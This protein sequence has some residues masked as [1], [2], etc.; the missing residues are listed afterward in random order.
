MFISLMI[1]MLKWMIEEIDNIEY[2]EN[3]HTQETRLFNAK[4]SIYDAIRDLEAY[5]MEAGRQREDMQ[6]QLATAQDE[7]ATLKSL[8]KN[9]EMHVRTGNDTIEE[10]HQQ[11]QQAQAEVA[12]D[13]AI[14]MWMDEIHL[15]LEANGELAT[16]QEEVETVNEKLSKYLRNWGMGPAVYESKIKELTQQL[17]QAQTELRNTNVLAEERGQLC[18]INVKLFRDKERQLQQAQADVKKWKDIAEQNFRESLTASKLFEQSRQREARLTTAL[19]VAKPAVEWMAEAIDSDPEDH[20][21][22]EI[23]IKALG[24]E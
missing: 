16:A 24:G 5:A 19:L 8:S 6:K 21:R 22:L 4:H 12:H 3:N 1:Y 15:R 14:K 17:Q 13:E 7:V 18:D 11:L 9:L 2:K 20:E 23:V 10:L